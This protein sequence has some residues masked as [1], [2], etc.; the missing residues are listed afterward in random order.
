MTWLIHYCN[1]MSDTRTRLNIWYIVCAD[2]LRL[3]VFTIIDLCRQHYRSRG[4]DVSFQEVGNTG[5]GLSL[6]NS[7]LKTKDSSSRKDAESE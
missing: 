4:E 2:D 5:G 7:S 3:K 6:M 1:G